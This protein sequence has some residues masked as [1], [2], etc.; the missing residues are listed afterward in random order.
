LAI[1]AVNGATRNPT[2]AMR[3]TMVGG[4]D[5]S[6]AHPTAT[7]TEPTTKQPSARVNV[8]SAA[9]ATSFAAASRC[10]GVEGNVPSPTP[11]SVR[12][13][14]C[15]HQSAATFSPT[16]TTASSPKYQPLVP[17]GMSITVAT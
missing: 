6:S 15:S 2:R 11:R 8:V 3:S 17:S 13:R 16:T 14:D 1:I 4:G 9:W 10:A 7:R 12:R 5:A